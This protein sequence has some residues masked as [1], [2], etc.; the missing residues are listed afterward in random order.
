MRWKLPLAL[1]ALLIPL[2]PVGTTSV[3][4]AAGLVNVPV[5]LL[6]RHNSSVVSTNWSGYA[7]DGEKFTK[8]QG[9]WTQPVAT[10]SGT[11]G[12]AAFWVGIDGYDSNSV[13]QLG[14]DSDC[15]GSTP[16]YYAW[17]EMYPA[18][19]VDLSKT[20]Y[21]VSPGDTLE[22]EVVV[23]G[24]AYLLAMRDISSSGTTKWTFIT[25]QSSTTATDASAEW[26]AEAPSECLIIC[27]VLPL[28]NFGTVQFQDAEATGNGSFGPITSFADNY[29][30]TMETSSGTVKAQPSALSGGGE[31]FSVTWHHS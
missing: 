20:T 23:N 12:Y 17:Y 16:S 7:V 13:E 28:S 1:G 30:I 2:A 11:S 31:D 3:A 26:V 19:S 10:C 18:G 25:H 4:A 6:Q 5:Q 14:T 15:S 24:S 9:A 29:A 22:A 21:P 27:E 8:V